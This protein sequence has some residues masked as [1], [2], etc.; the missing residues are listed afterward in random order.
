MYWLWTVSWSEKKPIGV[1]KNTLG[2]VCW[3]WPIL[4]SEKTPWGTF[5]GC[6]RYRVQKK[7]LGG[8]WDDIGVRK[9]T[10]G[11]VCLLGEHDIGIRKN[12]LRSV[13]W[14]RTILESE[15]QPFGVRKN[16][17]GDVCL[18]GVDDIGVKQ[19]P[20]GVTKNTFQGQQKHL[21]RLYYLTPLGVFLTPQCTRKP[22]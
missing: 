3:M 14:V 18:L 19:K 11:D 8:R 13:C 22:Y 2:A 16:T 12:T 7:H 17:L 5:A 9:R 21:F 6:G 10:V 1:R 4:E 20:T 15:K